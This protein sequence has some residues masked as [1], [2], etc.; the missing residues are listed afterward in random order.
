MLLS[1]NRQSFDYRQ[2][3]ICARAPMRFSRVGNVGKHAQTQH[4][5]LSF[6]RCNQTH[7]PEIDKLEQKKGLL[8]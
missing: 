4:I 2:V 8:F 3:E 6:A 5:R 7:K 1:N